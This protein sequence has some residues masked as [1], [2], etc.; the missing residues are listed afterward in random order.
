MKASKKQMKLPGDDSVSFCNIVGGVNIGQMGDSISTDGGSYI[1]LD[2]FELPKANLNASSHLKNVSQTIRGLSY[3]TDEQKAQLIDLVATLGRHLDGLPSAYTDE[4]E[5]VTKH[6]EVL[7]TGIGGKQ[8][9]KA[10]VQYASDGLRRSS[11]SLTEVAPTVSTIGPQI[12]DHVVS[13]LPT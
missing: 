3:G 12:A 7:M 1:G 5:M 9:D 6:M 13:M 11:M 4:A 10:M 2:T 8:P